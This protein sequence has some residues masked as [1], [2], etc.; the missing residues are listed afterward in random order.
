MQ[1]ISDP[2]TFWHAKIQYS[3][4][5]QYTVFLHFAKQATVCVVWNSKY[6]Y[7]LVLTIKSNT[8]IWKVGRFKT[9]KVSKKKP[10]PAS[11]HHIL[12]LDISMTHL[13]Y[14]I[15][16]KPIKTFIHS[17]TYEKPIERSA[18]FSWKEKSSTKKM[19]EIPSFI[20]VSNL[21]ECI[22]PMT[23]IAK[24]FWKHLLHLIQLNTWCQYICI[25]VSVSNKH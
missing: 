3:V 11:Y 8:Y 12:W 2:W 24:L 1:N 4:Y 9:S 6:M 10:V 25:T 22:Q 13:I 23:T 7:L 17:Y 19:L 15:K 20:K 5:L 21:L 14:I 18:V 16:L